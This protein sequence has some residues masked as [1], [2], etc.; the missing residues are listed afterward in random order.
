MY[1]LYRDSTSAPLVE[2]SPDTRSYV[3]TTAGTLQHTYRLVLRSANGGLSNAVSITATGGAGAPAAVVTLSAALPSGVSVAS[4]ALVTGRLLL[5]ASVPAGGSA[6][7]Q[8]SS[9]GTTWSA[10]DAASSCDSGVGRTH[11]HA[12]RPPPGPSSP[13]SPPRS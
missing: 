13:R 3:D 5:Q 12:A 2:L 11:C 7:F 9:D 4:G 10:V 8:F 6:L 1:D